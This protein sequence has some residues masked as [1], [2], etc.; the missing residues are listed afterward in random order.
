MITRKQ[1]VKSDNQIQKELRRS[2]RISQLKQNKVDERSRRRVANEPLYTKSSVQT[3]KEKTRKDQISQVKQDKVDERSRRRDANEPL[4]NK[5]DAQILKETAKQDR[6]E[7]DTLRKDMLKMNRTI[8]ELQKEVRFERRHNLR[9]EKHGRM[10]NVDKAQI[11][12]EKISRSYRR[13]KN[14][15]QRRVDLHQKIK[16]RLES[17]TIRDE[18]QEQYQEFFRVKTK[19]FQKI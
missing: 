17:K 5:S 4:Y 16:R 1:S 19:I 12:S 18:F 2:E 13:H 11:E 8:L 10:R 7:D 9:V 6:K 14:V 15:K 3:V